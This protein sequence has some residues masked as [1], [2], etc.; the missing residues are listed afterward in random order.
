MRESVIYQDIIQEG[1]KKEGR[2]LILRLL[3]RQVGEL[4]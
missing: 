1:E 2:S 4:P 3:I